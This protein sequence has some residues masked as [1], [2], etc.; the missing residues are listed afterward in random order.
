MNSIFMFI[1]NI[2]SQR[3]ETVFFICHDKYI[4]QNQAY[5]ITE[6]LFHHVGVVLLTITI[7]SVGIMHCFMIITNSWISEAHRLYVV[8]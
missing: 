5:D 6:D 4:V 3:T 2:W 7:F 8:L 1:M